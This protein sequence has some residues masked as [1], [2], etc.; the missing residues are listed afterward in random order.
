MNVSKNRA[1]SQRRFE[2]FV[3]F[4][5]TSQLYSGDASD[6]ICPK[7]WG[8][9]GWG[10]DRSYQ[11]L[12]FTFYNINNGANSSFTSNS[13][14]EYNLKINSKFMIVEKPFMFTL[15]GRYYIS[16][17]V[18]HSRQYGEYWG[19]SVGGANN[20]QITY[21]SANIL[22]TMTGDN[23]KYGY[24]VRCVANVVFLTCLC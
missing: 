9:G 2:K 22:H 5:Y 12:F 18:D 24:S 19:K 6:S 15:H 3:D 20:A 11:R 1:Y 17:G 13:Y 10:G 21:Y 23:I 4:T 14:N 8:M 16:G 7:G